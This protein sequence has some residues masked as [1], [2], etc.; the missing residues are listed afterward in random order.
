MNTSI[1]TIEV[2]TILFE[3][4]DPEVLV[5]GT[6]TKGHMTFE[7]DMLIS[8][9]QLNRLINQLQRQNNNLEM[10]QLLRS[11]KMYDNETL[12]TAELSSVSN[13]SINLRD[14]SVLRPVKQIRA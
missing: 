9:S 10:S 3:S 7:T 8:Q 1:R 14:L 5:K 4:N 11:D 2:N 6:M 13:R 12:Y